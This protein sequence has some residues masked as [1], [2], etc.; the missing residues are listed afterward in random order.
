MAF[1]GIVTRAVTH[2]IQNKLKTGRVVKIHQP[3]ATDLVMTIRANRKNY[4]LFLSVNPNFARFHLTDVKFQNP[5]EPPL[6]CMVLRKHLEGAVV[7]SVKQTG[8]ERV[9]TISFK[10]RN[11]L[12]DVSYKKLILELM[13]RHSNLIFLDAENNVIL[14]SMKHIPPSLSQFRTVLPGQ[15]YYNPPHMDKK[16]PLETEKEELLK[17]VDFNEGKMDKQLLNTFSGLSPQVIKEI[18]YRSGFL[19]SDSLYKAFTEVM[20]PVKNHNYFP[21][22][23]A[24]ENSESFSVIPLHY[25]SG[26]IRT[27]ETVHDL[28]DGYFTNKAERDRVK[29]RAYDLERLL[30][31]EYDKNK[32]KIKKLENTLKDADKAA[33]QQKYGELLTAHMHLVKPGQKEVQAVDYYDENQGKIIIPLNPQKSASANAQQYFK[34]Y[35]KL[36][37][38]VKFV[39]KEI[40]DAKIEMDY[41]DRLMQQM[42]LASTE[43]IEDIREELVQ[44][45]YLKKK[46]GR[47]KKKK[48]TKPMLD[49]YLSSSGIELYVGKNNKQNEY[50]T[51]RVSRQDDTWLHTKDIPGSHVL[52]RSTEPDEAAILEAANLAAYFSK[53]RMS[54]NVPVDYTLIRHV[55]KPNGAKPGYV[56]Y[57]KQTTVYVTPDER[58]VEKLKENFKKQPSS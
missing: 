54:G 57:D 58:L 38:S 8:L 49:R 10:G 22:M 39:R 6:F 11:E 21:Q 48:Q 51:T 34:K 26:E 2:D 42:E 24:E 47:K 9:V 28:L 52:I 30:K 56:T 1:D 41:F 32:K 40:K 14:E 31:N 18:L 50:L 13:G 4:P 44:G 25:K 46:V 45:G 29:Q 37:N 16:N 7:E 12:G 17:A 3:Y 43:D 33:E 5:Q 27:F 35:H 15:P 53:S 20:E 36:K 19:N 23:I 55:K